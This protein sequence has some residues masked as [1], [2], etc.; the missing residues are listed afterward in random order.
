MTMND[1]EKIADLEWRVSDLERVLGK[2]MEYAAECEVQ[3]SSYSEGS[4]HYR[5][6]F[7]KIKN[8]A[9]EELPDEE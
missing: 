7:N 2:I 4:A 6:I 9:A 5:R 1:N 3:E 8:M